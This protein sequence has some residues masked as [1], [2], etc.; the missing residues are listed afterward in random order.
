MC[1]HVIGEFLVLPK[2]LE[3]GALNQGHSRSPELVQL[4]GSNLRGIK[5]WTI[6]KFNVGTEISPRLEGFVTMPTLRKA[7]KSV[8]VNPEIEQSTV[9]PCMCL[10]LMSS[11][12]CSCGEP[13]KTSPALKGWHSVVNRNGLRDNPLIQ[14][15]YQVP[16][17]GQWNLMKDVGMVQCVQLVMPALQG[18]EARPSE[19]DSRWL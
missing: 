1:E 7:S 14:Q 6:A 18:P 3:G 2:S 11:E 5:L 16:R 12:E 13:S 15:R 4:H 9:S 8:S 19:K 17:L 10:V